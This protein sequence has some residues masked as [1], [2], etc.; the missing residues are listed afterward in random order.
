MITVDDIIWKQVL[1]DTTWIQNVAEINLV[2]K[3]VM[4]K[5]GLLLENG[6]E[7][8]VYTWVQPHKLGLRARVSCWQC[9]SL[10]GV[11]ISQLSFISQQI[12]NEYVLCAWPN[13][14][15]QYQLPSCHCFSVSPGAFPKDYVLQTGNTKLKYFYCSAQGGPLLT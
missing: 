5:V 11:R 8:I 10:G 14:E 13:G 7:K 15:D 1:R 9:W 6:L 3:K 4:G 2:I 12:S